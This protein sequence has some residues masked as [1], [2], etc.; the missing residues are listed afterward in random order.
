MEDMVKK[1]GMNCFVLLAVVL[2]MSVFVV[3]QV[4]SDGSKVGQK[5][6]DIEEN[7]GKPGC[8]LLAALDG[9]GE[10]VGKAELDAILNDPKTSAEELESVASQING[11]AALKDKFADLW[12]ASEKKAEL[13]ESM[14]KASQGDS[15]DDLN[16]LMTEI[17]VKN[18]AKAGFKFKF[19]AAGEIGEV[20][21]DEAKGV[22]STTVDNV[23]RVVPLNVPSHVDSMTLGGE[24]VDYVVNEGSEGE[25]LLSITDSGYVTSSES[26]RGIVLTV[27][28]SS[29]APDGTVVKARFPGETKGSFIV[30]TLNHYIK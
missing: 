19:D 24:S 27:S 16:G 30:T 26:N 1:K 29:G 10:N 23:E 22:I 2:L 8:G 18:G 15:K 20:K 14:L 11:D 5:Y 6:C 4:D 3:G 13:F 9:D 21:F 7:K 28:D 12:K 17:Y 25:N